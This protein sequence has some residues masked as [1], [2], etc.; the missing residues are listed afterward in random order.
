MNKRTMMDYLKRI[1]ITEL[2]PQNEKGLNELIQSHLRTVPFENLDV[3]DFGMI[4]KLSEEDICEKIVTRRRGGYCFELNTLFLKLLLKTGYEG[5]SV[6]VRVMWNRD[7]LPPVSHMGLVVYVDGRKY[8]SDVGFGGPGPKGPLLLEEGEQWIAGEK[9]WVEKSADEDFIIKRKNS[10]MWKNV[11]CFCDRPVREP[12][13]EL[14][15]FYCARNENVLFSRT[16]VVNLC[17]PDGSKALT[18][19]ILTVRKKNE[20]YRVIYENQDKLEKGL[21][22]EFGIKISLSQKKE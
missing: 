13:W 9:F 10:G 11:L 20:E 15:N 22:Q 6:A 17:T 12:D 7:Y 1:H 14:M 16:R 18:G 5:Y 2:P 19:R 21:E 3:V 4:P 8:Y